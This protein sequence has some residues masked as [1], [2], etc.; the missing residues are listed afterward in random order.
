VLVGERTE[1]LDADEVITR[2]KTFIPQVNVALVPDAGHAFP[3]DHIDL[4]LS[5][6]EQLTPDAL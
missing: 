2:A 4:V 1:P 5:H 3:V 6:I